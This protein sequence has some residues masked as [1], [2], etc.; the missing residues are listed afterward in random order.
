MTCLLKG[1]TGLTAK[2]IAEKE[3]IFKGD[4]MEVE[5]EGIKDFRLLMMAARFSE[6]RL[7]E[8]RILQN[9]HSRELVH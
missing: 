2:L 7:I 3:V 8:N 6:C 9:H 5:C 4:K 1:K